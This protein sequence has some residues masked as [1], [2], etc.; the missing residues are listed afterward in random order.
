M[1]GFG[2]STPR[3]LQTA[4]KLHRLLSEALARGV[5]GRSSALQD[6]RAIAINRVEITSNLQLAR[7]HWEPMGGDAPVRKL[8][9]SDVRTKRSK[10]SQ[11]PSMSEMNV[12]LDASD[13]SS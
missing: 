3:S 9:A 10:Y 5:V 11:L 7:V 4:A 12:T 2:T 8:S 1:G 6:G 13:P